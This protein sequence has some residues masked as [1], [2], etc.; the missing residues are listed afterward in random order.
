MKGNELIKGRYYKIT[1]F[2]FIF[3]FTKIKIS[4]LYNQCYYDYAINKLEFKKDDCVSDIWGFEEATPI[5]I[6]Q[7]IASQLSDNFVTKEALAN[8]GIIPISDICKIM[9]PI[10]CK[11]KSLC[12][13]GDVANET[14]I[15]SR[16]IETNFD[17]KNIYVKG[18]KFNL[19][20]YEDNQFAEIISYHDEREVNVNPVLH[21]FKD[22]AD[23]PIELEVKKWYK[24]LEH[25]YIRHV[26]N[27]DPYENSVQSDLT[28][29]I[30]DIKQSLSKIYDES[31]VNEIVELLEN[32]KK[33]KNNGFDKVP[34]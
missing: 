33:K 31:D 8:F 25:Q 14:S 18:S 34:F 1:E 29:T 7:L 26:N 23:K 2:N 16:M 4:P 12:Y 13:W 11:I 15:V 19:K 6:A 10:G 30:F 21:V 24:D 17:N 28:F 27:I 9:Y 3:R 20:V 32:S 22:I 5:E